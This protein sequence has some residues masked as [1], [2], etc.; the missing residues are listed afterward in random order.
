M[1]YAILL[2]CF[3]LLLCSCSNRE[4]YN[5]IQARERNRCYKL[6]RT[7]QQECLDRV[8]GSYDDYKKAKDNL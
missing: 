3:C 1:K 5:L 2:P 4:I 8:G 7:Q 6:P